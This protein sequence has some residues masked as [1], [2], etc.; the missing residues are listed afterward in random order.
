MPDDWVT[1]G[2]RAEAVEFWRAL[3]I[4]PFTAALAQGDGYGP[5]SARHRL[6]GLRE[7]AGGWRAEGMSD[8]DSLRWHRA[9]FSAREAA[10]WSRRGTSLEEAALATGHRMVG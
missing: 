2:V 6:A 8:A 10:E 4:D 1:L 3:E 5:S 9:G 7:V